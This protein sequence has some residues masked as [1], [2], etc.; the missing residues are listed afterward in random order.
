M[1]VELDQVWQHPDQ[2][3]SADLALADAAVWLRMRSFP[4]RD[5]HGYLLGREVYSMILPGAISSG[6]AL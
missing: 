3:Y 6:I 2:E 4:V 5:N 1:K